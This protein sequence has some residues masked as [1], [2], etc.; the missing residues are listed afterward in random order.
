MYGWYA[1]VLLP[2]ARVLVT[3][4]VCC[5]NLLPV[6]SGWLVYQPYYFTLFAGVYGARGYLARGNGTLH[7]LFK[8][9]QLFC[10]IHCKV[11]L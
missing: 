11:M 2:G 1:H 4:I 3:I 5:Y 8:E 7:V 6:S 9:L 10:L